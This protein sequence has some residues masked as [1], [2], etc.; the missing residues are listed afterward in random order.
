MT[1][2]LLICAFLAI[3]ATV[4]LPAQQGTGKKFATRDPFVCKSKKDPAKGAPSPDQIKQYFRCNSETGERSSGSNYLYLLDNITVEV[5]AGRPYQVSEMSIPEIDP[6]KLVYPI[7][8]SFDR[9][10]CSDP[11]HA[12]Q[13]ARGNSVSPPGKNCSLFL[14]PHATG[15]CW[16]TTFGDWDCTMADG[17]A[18][19]R[20]DRRNVMGPQ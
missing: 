3:G 10:Q 13:D 19:Y 2:H 5:G 12:S 14:A 17:N 16:R 9:Y 4:A 18:S 6:S 1:R 20:P 7:R 15:I 8:G 11:A